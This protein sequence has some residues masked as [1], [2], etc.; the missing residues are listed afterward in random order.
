MTE[1]RFLFRFFVVAVA[2]VL[3]CASLASLINAG[4]DNS[5]LA[6]IRA[7]TKES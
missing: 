3:L 7:R 4:L 1:A 5:A 6:A 2:V